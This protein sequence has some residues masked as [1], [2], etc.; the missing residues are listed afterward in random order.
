M[1]FESSTGN[2]V[3]ATV[4]RVIRHCCEGENI[5]MTCSSAW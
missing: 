4:C 1:E 2:G 5:R 3:N